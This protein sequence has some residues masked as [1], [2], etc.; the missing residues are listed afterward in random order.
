M[1]SGPQFLVSSKLVAHP[2]TSSSA[3]IAKLRL[4]SESTKSLPDYIEIPCSERHRRLAV[5]AECAG[6]RLDQALARLMP[7]YSRNRLQ[8]WMRSGHITL[9][10]GSASAKTKVWGG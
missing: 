1:R 4:M 3:R 6:L 2:A 8:E 5:P 7:E 10:G 9:D